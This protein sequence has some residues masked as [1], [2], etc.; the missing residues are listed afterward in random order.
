MYAKMVD[1]MLHK[2]MLWNGA[3]LECKSEALKKVICVCSRKCFTLKHMY[4]GAKAQQMQLKQ[5]WF[6]S[7]GHEAPKYVLSLGTR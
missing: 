7:E 1:D 5:K 2:I 3:I 6:D 4:C